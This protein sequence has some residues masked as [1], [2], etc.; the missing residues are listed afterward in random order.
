MLVCSKQSYP[1]SETSILK[2]VEISCT[3]FSSELYL[4]KSPT[5]L[6]EEGDPG[7]KLLS[8][9]GFSRVGSGYPD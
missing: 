1:A 9:E 3:G 6:G 7:I 2:T 5:Q 4:S 8:W